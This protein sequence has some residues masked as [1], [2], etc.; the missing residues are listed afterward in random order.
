[1]FDFGQ[2]FRNFDFGQIFEKKIEFGQNYR[3]FPKIS[4]LLK[5]SQIFDFGQIFEKFRFFRKVRRNSILVKFSK[6]SILVKFS[7]IS[8]LAEIYKKFVVSE[9]LK[10][11]IWVNFSKNFEFGQNF[12]QISFFRKF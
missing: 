6:S 11:P 10:I 12:E 5:L 1:M 2:I 4:N 9:F 8:I 3:K 7:E